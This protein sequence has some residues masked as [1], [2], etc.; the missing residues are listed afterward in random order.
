MGRNR[1]SATL[2]FLLAA[3]RC[4]LHDLEDLAGTCELVVQVGDLVHALQKERGYTNLFLRTQQTLFPPTLADLQEEAL[5]VEV[6]TRGLLN[7]LLGG[8][9]QAVTGKTRLF[10]SI[11]Y[12]LHRLDDC[13]DLRWRIRERRVESQQATVQFTRLIASLLA[14]V[15]EAA[16]TALDPD[17][18][19]T[20]VAL[21]NFMQGKEL[22]GQERALGV[23][24]YAEGYFT[25]EQ[26]ARM[27]ELAEGQERCFGIFVEY[28]PDEVLQQWEIIGN[29]SIPVERMRA[30][31]R[32]TSPENTVD[33]GL[34]EL[35]YDMATSRI[36]AMRTA[37]RMLAEG[38]AR[39][40]RQRIADTREELDNHHLLMSRFTDQAESETPA[41]L[42]NIQSCPI[43][44]PLQ[45]GL[46]SDMARSMLDI[47]HEQR[48]RMDRYD[49]ELARARS[50]LDERKTIEQA[51][52]LLV[53]HRKLSEQAAHSLLQQTAMRNGLSLAEVARRILTD[54]DG[55]SSS[56][57]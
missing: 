56:G 10:N 17:V 50:A 8:E 13:V 19:R 43:D 4:E 18:T 51:K 34:G 48:L 1:I 11:A 20:L 57:A 3:R 27:L 38:L 14:V 29:C 44:A 7:K 22:S 16:D 21:F 40:C 54:D 6:K 46:A 41:R 32:Q 31:L 9:A 42:F 26:K 2:S 55:K 39:L 5:Q 35:W 33:K 24:G 25:Q 28:A 15:F 37:E 53:Q 30:M 12:A 45:D 23:M 52:W 36:D 49:A 47:M